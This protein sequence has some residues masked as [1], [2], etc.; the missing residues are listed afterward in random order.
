[1]L[2]DTTTIV[3]VE[4]SDGR[5]PSQDV[6]NKYDWMRI[7]R[8]QI[9]CCHRRFY[10]QAD[11]VPAAGIGVVPNYNWHNTAAVLVLYTTAV[12]GIVHQLHNGGQIQITGQGHLLIMSIQWIAVVDY[13][14]DGRKNGR[15]EICWMTTIIA[16]VP[17]C[18]PFRSIRCC[19]CFF[20]K[21]CSC[22]G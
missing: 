19:F 22:V 21:W 7:F 20:Y 17:W 14:R 12:V 9:F 10:S 13:W 3:V 15:S 1:V 2:R 18:F 6:A 16:D 11:A 5:I 4:N 8:C